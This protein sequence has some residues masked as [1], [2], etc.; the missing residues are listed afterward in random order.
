[1]LVL[2][3]RQARKITS[4]IGKTMDLSEKIARM[5][6]EYLTDSQLIAAVMNVGS[7]CVR[8]SGITNEVIEIAGGVERLG[9]LS[10]GELCAVKGVGPA[11]ASAI[12]AALE[13]GKRALCTKTFGDRLGSSAE[14]YNAFWPVTASEAIEV[15]RCALVDAKLRLIKT[16]VIS[17]GILNAS[18]VHPRE[19]F[20]PAV[21]NSASGVIFIHNHP[22]GDPAPSREDRAMTERLAKVGEILGVPLLDHVIIGGDGSYYSFADAGAVQATASGYMGTIFE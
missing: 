12:I 18:I 21:R 5:G 13:L 17:R 2:L 7:I 15:F 6:V 8:T 3:L 16:E 14:V 19:A 11:R 22:S 4:D 10:Y 9:S 1:M 20:R